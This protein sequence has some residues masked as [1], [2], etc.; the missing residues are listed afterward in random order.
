MCNDNSRKWKG[1]RALVKPN[2]KFELT[3]D[4][5]SLIEKALQN[6]ISK[7][8]LGRDTL[9]DSTIKQPDEITSV[10][11]SNAKIREVQDLLARIYH[12]KNWYRPKDKI[13]VSG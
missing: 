6:E 10:Q 11:E 3:V 4:D 2:T 8:V 13:Y 1:T 7:L 9:I 12:Q 5:I